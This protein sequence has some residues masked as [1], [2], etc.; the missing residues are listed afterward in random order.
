MN[1]VSM[2]ITANLLGLGNAATPLG[3][4]AMRGLQANNP[5]PEIASD[6]W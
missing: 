6:E 3:L 1:A 2:N 4:E 5:T